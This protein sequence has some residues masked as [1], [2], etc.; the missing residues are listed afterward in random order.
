MLATL[1]GCKRPGPLISALVTVGRWSRYEAVGGYMIEGFLDFNPSR[2]DLEAQ[3]T[4]KR[5]AGRKGGLR[6]AEVRSASSRNQ[7]GASD[8]V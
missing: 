1:H 4:S 2:A 8:V 5:E 3:R 7:A 6:S